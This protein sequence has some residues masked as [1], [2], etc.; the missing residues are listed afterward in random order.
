MPEDV[1]P[2]DASPTALSPED[3]DSRSNRDAVIQGLLRFAKRAVE[4][5]LAGSPSFTTDPKAKAFVIAN[6]FAFLL[7]VI[8]DQH[9]PVEKA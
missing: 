1:H 4:V 6:P 8:C 5:Q 7:A 9:I 2:T 3:R